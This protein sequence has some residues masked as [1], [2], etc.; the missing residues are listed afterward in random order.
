MEQIRVVL[1]D[2]HTILRQG[3]RSLLANEEDI[4]LVGE[5]TDGREAVT[6]VEE[7]LPDVVVMD[8]SMKM[9]N[10]VEATRH[11]MEQ[12]PAVKIVVLSI[13][14]EESYVGSALKAGAAGYVLKSSAYD[15]LTQAIRAAARGELFLSPAIS[16]VVVS[17]YLDSLKPKKFISSYERLTPR[18]RELLQLLAEGYTRRQIAELLHISP[19]TVSRHR[20]DIMHNLD[21]HDDAGLVK[22][23]I[24]VGIVDA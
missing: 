4:V 12:N 14:H 3:L 7:L 24:N 19:K 21:I 17:G 18:Q 13:H 2:D 8:I 9:L 15:E 6:L 11:I 22:F 16:P 1:A 5:A 23:A 10:G 20:E